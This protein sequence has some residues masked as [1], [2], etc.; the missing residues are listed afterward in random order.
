MKICTQCRIEKAPSEF[1][2]DKRYSDGLYPSCRECKRSKSR[3]RYSANK[4]RVTVDYPATKKCHKCKVYLSLDNFS[5]DLG[6]P[7]GVRA[8][9]KECTN[10]AL[11]AYRRT[12]EGH[13]KDLLRQYTQTDKKRG[14]MCDLTL[15]FIKENITSQPCIYCGDTKKIGCDRL[16]NNKAHTKDN[17]VPC[18]FDCNTAR[19][20]NFTHEEMLVL[21]E[22]IRAIK[23]ER[24]E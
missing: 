10:A 16:D 18:C 22:T 9:C 15:G 17:V 19:N 5:K 12:E 11:R 6:R 14:L 7:D 13:M 1:S 8:T 21:G 3:A 23:E 4:A 2:K 24:N 20:D